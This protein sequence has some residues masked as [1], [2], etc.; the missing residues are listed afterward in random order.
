MGGRRHARPVRAT[1]DRRSPLRDH[2]TR[3]QPS[4]G[5][6]SLPSITRRASVRESARS[7][8][9]RGHRLRTTQQ[10]GRVN[11]VNPAH[12]AHVMA[13]EMAAEH[14]A[15]T[16]HH[17]RTDIRSKLHTTLTVVERT[18]ALFASPEGPLKPTGRRDIASAPHRSNCHRRSSRANVAKAFPLIA[19]RLTEHASAAAVTSRAHAVQDGRLQPGH[20]RPHRGRMPTDPHAPPWAPPPNGGFHPVPVHTL[21]HTD[22]EETAPRLPG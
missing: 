1:V 5:S 10:V 21:P 16:Q 2:P 19:A 20:C 15:R 11:A 14:E 8:N 13:V 6:T 4:R 9:R 7:A 17:F 3:R 22:T 18:S 12:R